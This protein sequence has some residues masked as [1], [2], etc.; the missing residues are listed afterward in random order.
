V[1]GGIDVLTLRPDPGGGL[2]VAEVLAFLDA[3][4]LEPFGLPRVLHTPAPGNPP[5]T[6]DSRPSPGFHP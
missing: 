5:A 6:D 2:E 3:D 1:G 4:L